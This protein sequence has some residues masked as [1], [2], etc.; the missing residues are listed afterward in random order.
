MP[1]DSGLPVQTKL[2]LAGTI[3]LTGHAVLE[4]G[5]DPLATLK[6]ASLVGAV[7]TDILFLPI[8]GNDNA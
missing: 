5:G 1:I 8:A 6:K 2:Q 3:N 7:A 4:L